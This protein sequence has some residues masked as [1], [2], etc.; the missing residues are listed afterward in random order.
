METDVS[1]KVLSRK[2]TS[3]L[4]RLVHEEGVNVLSVDA[5]ELHDVSRRVDC[6]IKL[7]GKRGV[8]YRHFEFQ[9][10][11][12]PDM[13]KRCFRY[14]TQL[15]LQLDAPVLTTVVYLTPP[16]PKE[17]TL[18][19]RVILDGEEINVWRFDEVRLWEISAQDALESRAPGFLTLVPFMK[20]GRT[21]DVLVR[22]VAA[23]RKA[24]PGEKNP[25][26]LAIL[27]YFAGAYY[28]VEELTRLFGRETMIQS[29]V[30]QAAWSEGKAEG[31]AEGILAEQRALCLELI[32]LHHPGLSAKAAAA[33]QACSE[34]AALR[35]WI[36]RATQLDTPAFA[37]LLGI[38]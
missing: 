21:W 13:A 18:A 9:S 8:Y 3:G 37:R 35:T 10:E 1:L 19:F 20:G 31:K 29:S 4:L 33:V 30:W 36:L 17:P 38:D 32:K 5:V 23:I 24:L 16:G 34:P 22:A 6:L 27:A 2:Y 12:D 7:Q 28:N 26:A 25:E 14:N 15:I 11:P